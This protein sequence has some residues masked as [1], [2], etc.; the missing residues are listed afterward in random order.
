MSAT[1]KLDYLEE[2][3]TLIRNAIN[4]KGV[5]VTEN[6]TFRSYADKIVS[7]RTSEG[8]AIGF[9]GMAPFGIN[10]EENTKR[11]LNGQVISQVQ[12]ET[13]TAKLKDAVALNPAL[14]TTE[15]NWQAEVTNSVNGTCGKFVIDDTAG[16][17]RLPK[18]PEYVSK[19]YVESAVVG[20]G[21]TLGLSDGTNNYGTTAFGYTSNVA[22]G[23]SPTNEYGGNVGD[24]GTFATYVTNNILSGVT[25]DPEKSGIIAD[26]KNATTETIPCKWFIQVANEV[27]TSVDVTRQIQLNNPF[28]LLEYKWSEYEITNA[29]WLISNGSFNSGSLYPSVYELL[30]KI[31]NGVETKAGV[32]VKAFEEEYTDYDFVINTAHETFRLPLKVKLASGKAVAGNGMSLGLTD[33]SNTYGLKN[34]GEVVTTST[35]QHLD[36]T[37][38]AY[39]KN[40][41]DIAESID[42]PNDHTVLGVTEDGNYSGIETSSHGLFLY[43]Y[44]GETIQDANLINANGVLNNVNN[45]LSLLNSIDYVVESKVAT[46]EDPSWYRVYK[47][48]WVEQGGTILQAGTPVTYLKAFSNNSYDIQATSVNT[49]SVPSSDCYLI[50]WNTTETGFEEIRGRTFPVKWSAKGQGAL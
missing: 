10:E 46:D 48:G 13:F 38:E 37:T 41:G 5:E 15:E 30:L 7:I 21:M 3:K 16:T 45:I 4:E 14:A 29:S 6:D 17:I 27:E 42:R 40:I 23:V 11:Y 49:T 19:E 22:R 31:Y 18:Y 12:F 25:T 2:T 44:V 26:L 9:I 32:S 1:D 43:F 24:N 36:V 50:V 20:N 39:G 8:F 33:G 28:T 34:E 35:W 47:S